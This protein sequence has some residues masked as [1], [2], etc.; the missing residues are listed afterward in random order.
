[1]TETKMISRRRKLSQ[2]S[3][4]DFSTYCVIDYA[5]FLLMFKFEVHQIG[6]NWKKKYSKLF[7]SNAKSV[8]LESTAIIHSPTQTKHARGRTLTPEV[9]TLFVTI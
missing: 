9:Q 7:F 2:I 1:M 6:P 3:Y 5:N 4:A 8:F